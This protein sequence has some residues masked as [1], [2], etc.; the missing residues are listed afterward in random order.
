VSGT[1]TSGGGGGAGGAA[2]AGPSFTA[3][4]NK[5]LYACQN[6]ACHASDNAAVR[7]SIDM[8]TRDA[9]YASLV[10]NPMPLDTGACGGGKGFLKVDKANPDKSLI[11]TKLN[12]EGD[13]RPP[14]GGPMP[15]GG[16]FEPEMV[17]AIKAWIV[18]GAPNN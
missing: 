18:A 7:I 16:T 3:L 11:L 2:A 5:E 8:R 10:T 13:P 14:C 9:A 4:F 15:P 12:V 1:T 17:A 6:P